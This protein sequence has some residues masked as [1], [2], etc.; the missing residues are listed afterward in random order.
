MVAIYRQTKPEI[1]R[2]SFEVIRIRISPPCTWPNGETSP[3]RETYPGN[4]TWGV[5]GFTLTTIDAA[6]KKMANL[7][8]QSK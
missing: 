1:S 2:D 6:R 8:L 3:E 5:N 7:Y 4:E